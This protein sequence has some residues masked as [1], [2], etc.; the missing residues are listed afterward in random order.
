MTVCFQNQKVRYNSRAYKLLA[1]LALIIAMDTFLYA[2]TI[3]EHYLELDVPFIIDSHMHLLGMGTN[4]SGNYTNPQML[5]SSNLFEYGKSMMLQHFSGIRTHQNADLEYVKRLNEYVSTQNNLPVNYHGMIFAFSPTYNKKTGLKDL[6]STT[7]SISNTYVKKITRLSDR[8]IPVASLHPYQGD[9]EERFEKIVKG[10]FN[11]LKILPN[12]MGIDPS[13]PDCDNFFS[14]L[15][16]YRIVL[17][18]HVG[19]EHSVSYGGL[20][21]E[22]GSPRHYYKW[23]EKYPDLKII[24]AHVGSEGKSTDINGQKKDNFEQVLELLKAYPKRAFADI[25]AFTISVK[26]IPFIK[27]LLESES[28]HGQLLYGSDYPLPTITPLVY[29]AIVKIAWL[30]LLP[31]RLKLKDLISIYKENPLVFNVV[32]M[33]SLEYQGYRFPKDVF[34]YN[35]FKTLNPQDMTPRLHTLRTQAEQFKAAKVLS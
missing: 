21:N 22:F 19:D 16:K 25:S 4:N 14:L 27:R 10:K 6:E 9:L 33:M 5:K 34:Y 15:A 29:P 31:P 23:L 30:G 7:F 2:R 32:L 26:R 8:Y 13:D 12:S 24:F 18:T 20:D 1:S 35:L 3:R 28:I 11:F 17:I